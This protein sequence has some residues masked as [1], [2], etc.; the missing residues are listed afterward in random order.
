[1]VKVGSLKNDRGGL[2]GCEGDKYKGSRERQGQ[3]ESVI[4]RLGNNGE[5]GLNNAYCLRH[6]ASQQCVGGASIGLFQGGQAR[7][8]HA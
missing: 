8:T 4:I 7:R 5:G 2:K 3:N 1:M 6:V